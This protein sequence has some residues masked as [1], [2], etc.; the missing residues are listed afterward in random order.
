LADVVHLRLFGPAQVEYADHTVRDLPFG[1]ALA[2]LGYLAVQGRPVSREHLA[3]LLWPDKSASRGRANLSWQL[4]HLSTLAPGRL[5]A[6]P[7]AVRFRRDSSRGLDLDG[8]TALAEEKDAVALADAAALYRGDLLEGLHLDGCADFEVW[9]TGERERWRRWA[10]RLLGDLVAHHTELGERHEALRYA[11]RLL[12]L[13]PWQEEAHRQVM[14]LLALDGQRAAALRQYDE[15]ARILE[16]ELGLPPSEAT[17]ALYKEIRAAPALTEP[18]PLV[19][20]RPRHNLPAQATRFVGREDE[21]AAIQSRLREP[22]CRLLSLVGPGGSGKTRLALEAAAAQ[23]D[24][25]EHGVFFC[26]LAPLRSVETIAPAIAEAVEFRLYGAK[27]PRQQLLEYLG[28]KNILLVLDNVEHLLG[29]H[30]SPPAQRDQTGAADLVSDLLAA[31]PG[32]RILAT[33]RVRL[34]VAGEHVFPVK[35]MSVPDPTSSTRATPVEEGQTDAGQADAVRLFLFSARRAEPNFALTPANQADV[36]RICRLVEGLPLGI[37]LAAT[38]VH[39]LSPAEIVAQMQRSLDFLATDQHGVP[40]RQRSMRATLDHSWGLLSADE[41][42]A[43]QELS[44]FRGGFA[45]EAAQE[46]AGA[47]LR[48]LLSLANHSLL[49]RTPDGRC[50][51]HELVRQYA[52]EQLDR[53]PEVAQAARDRHSTYYLSWIQGLVTDLK[54]PEQVATLAKVDG[55]IDNVRAAWTWAVTQEQ[56]AQVERALEPLARY[57]HLRFY[58]HEGESVFRLAASRLACC[59]WEQGE[60]LDQAHG[61]RV[62]V[63]AKLLAWQGVYEHSYGNSERAIQ[64]LQKSLG[65][66]ERLEAATWDTRQEKAF[67]LRKLGYNMLWNLHDREGAKRLYE[68]SLALYKALGDHWE[69]GEVL[70]RLG[71]LAEFSSAYP[72]ARELF[73]QSLALL[74]TTG[75]YA[76]IIWTLAYLSIINTHL[77]E[78]EVA[79]RKVREGHTLLEQVGGRD[80]FM[81][82]LWYLGWASLGL[83]RFAEAR[84]A[85]QERLA[86]YEEHRLRDLSVSSIALLGL[87]QVDLGQYGE[88]RDHAQKG[89]SLAQ[90]TGFQLGEGLV[91]LAL[92]RVAMAERAYP[93]AQQRLRESVAAHEQAGAPHDRGVALSAL[94]LAARALGRPDPARQH[95]CR[96]LSAATDGGSCLPLM[97]GLPGIA[98][99]LAD[100][101]QHER[102]I[103]VYALASRYPCVANSR[104]YADVVGRPLA[105]LTG[106]LPPEVIAHA[107]ARGRARELRATATELLAELEE[108]GCAPNT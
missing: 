18:R 43:L 14:R 35:G 70:G 67:V 28:P 76:Q 84:S 51:V 2:L 40:E 15:C 22:G 95:L 19:P 1:K 62:H 99:L 42:E 85:G 93:E 63:W 72:K 80:Q 32:I 91:L 10:G 21:L 105:A 48:M 58:W 79:E 108:M 64:L 89:L 34:N 104:W 77:G 36:A 71:E 54:G 66:L 8:F 97:H 65:L 69:M 26:S 101:G 47:S 81:V 55:E 30:L 90:D 46:V 49:E 82:A 73:E 17:T 45:H 94:G 7:D 25:F 96:A 56:V 107:Q 11:R 20:P 61:D 78:I 44:V 68:E 92:G 23:I 38:W 41:Q 29:K 57:Y 83:G 86:F 102:A 74:K 5:D 59:E 12:E 106:H 98:L 50:H 39:L 24:R 100:A 103:E 31:A 6:T 16:S 88:A 27:E 37:L 13:E 60:S 33:L 9:L 53:A 75:D 4:H 3:D 52:E 87:A